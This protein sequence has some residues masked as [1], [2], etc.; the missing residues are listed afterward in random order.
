LGLT[1]T[2]NLAAAQARGHDDLLRGPVCLVGRA[3][4]ALGIQR[5]CVSI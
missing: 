5:I 1:D 3:I 2:V 4:V